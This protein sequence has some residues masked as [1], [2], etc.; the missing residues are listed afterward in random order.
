MGPLFYYD[1]VRLARRG[2]SVLLRCAYA[3]AVFVNLYLAYRARFP[4][5]ELWWWPFSS[6]ASLHPRELSRLGEEFVRGILKV[7]TAAIFVLAPAYVA[8]VI[9]GEKERRSLDLLF[10]TQLRDREIVLGKLAA[11]L[12]HLGMLLLGALPLL[13]LTA[14]WGGT[15]VRLLLTASL[16]AGMYLFAVGALSIFCSVLART[17]FSALVASYL[18][19]SLMTFGSP[20]LPFGQTVTPS[21][22]YAALQEQAA[23]AAGPAAAPAAPPPIFRPVGGLG[24]PR[25]LPPPPIFPLPAPA[26]APISVLYGPLADCVAWNGAVALLATL[27]AVAALRPLALHE[28]RRA[29]K[30]AIP[31]PAKAKAARPV[32]APAGPP[33]AVRAAPRVGDW[34]LLWKEIYRRGPG[35]LD[36]PAGRKLRRAWPLLL[37]VVF[38][39]GFV[40]YAALLSDDE[41]LVPLPVRF[42]LY[43]IGPADLLRMAVVAA[44]ALWGVIAAFH[45][46]GV[47]SR[48]RD[49]NTLDSLLVLPVSRAA[50]LL[51][52]LAGSVARGRWA[53]LA[54][55][56]AILLGTLSGPFHPEVHLILVLSAVAT[57]TFWA[58]VG[59][60]LSVVSRTAL[61]ARLTTAGA[62][63]LVFGGW[64]YLANDAAFHRQGAVGIRVPGVPDDS[65]LAAVADV[66][67]NPLRAWWFLGVVVDS[68]LDHHGGEFHQM[69][70]RLNAVAAG[71]I[72]YGLLAR[73][74]WADACRRFRRGMRD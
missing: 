50:I 59:L 63:L 49:G 28:R 53:V 15:D 30:A 60:W 34:P 2:S 35:M 52:K 17:A 14:L 33:R 6:P 45:A 65:W 61:R 12:A 9:A 11:R 47:V 20:L 54:F 58:S 66:G 56:A 5:D 19:V 10:T 44:A 72:A 36:S 13:A 31:A 29:R 23:A 67:V 18:L 38:V 69:E 3:L 40:S 16:A 73:L 37:L 22:L 41:G 1:L 68:A 26:P 24:G 8:G 62:L 7:Q 25:R 46:A 4:Q 39:V 48:E 64:L 71:V 55:A 51:A 21:R 32:P 57:V 43:K 70:V 74:L 42:F 27:V